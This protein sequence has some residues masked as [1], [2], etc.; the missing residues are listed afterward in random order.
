[1]KNEYKTSEVSVA[2]NAPKYM[3]EIM[4]MIVEENPNLVESV[5]IGIDGEL[6]IED[7]DGISKENQKRLIDTHKKLVTGILAFEEALLYLG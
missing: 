7:E 3:H 2:P 1:M 6:I 5:K 4:K